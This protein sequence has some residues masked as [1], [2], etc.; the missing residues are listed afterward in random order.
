MDDDTTSHQPPLQY[1][2][3]A[4]HLSQVIETGFASGLPSQKIEQA[5][6]S[7]SRYE[8]YSGMTLSAA[9]VST[10]MDLGHMTGG[11]GPVDQAVMSP[12]EDE[13]LS[14][15]DHLEDISSA[16]QASESAP[17]CPPASMDSGGGENHIQFVTLGALRQNNCTPRS[18]D[19]FEIESG[20]SICELPGKAPLV[21][22][23]A[24]PA[25]L[26]DDEP[27]ASETSS[28]SALDVTSHQTV[29]DDASKEPQ[30]IESMQT[31]GILQLDLHNDESVRKVVE[32]LDSLGKLRELGFKK[33]MPTPADKTEDS[34]A[35]L[36]QEHQ[37]P[38][39]A[40]KC[41]K[42]FARLCELK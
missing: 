30:F 37:Y 25:L 18:S 22:A 4:P 9:P 11:T 1:N 23:T 16:V 10:Y 31:H 8:S 32:A 3:G 20:Q 39:L 19:N 38:C 17:D 7:S 24:S 35:R 41:D 13:R 28:I 40:E 5:A 42:T 21:P 12:S 34:T 29:P 26:A 27:D 33:D 2:S 15:T 6:G 14:M 36:R